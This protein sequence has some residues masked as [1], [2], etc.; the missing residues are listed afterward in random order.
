MVTILVANVYVYSLEKW[1]LRQFFSPCY[2][3]QKN[4]K[5]TK[6]VEVVTKDFSFCKI[7][8]ISL[9]CIFVCLGRAFLREK[10][11]HKILLSLYIGV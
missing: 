2:K 11:K 1:L 7:R 8:S 9:K 6:R 3:K 10:I 4:V 5:F